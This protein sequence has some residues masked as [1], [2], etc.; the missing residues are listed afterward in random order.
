MTDE[1]VTGLWMTHGIAAGLASAT[2]K[3][4]WAAAF[5]ASLAPIVLS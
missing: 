4:A 1:K 3:G 5:F 2:G